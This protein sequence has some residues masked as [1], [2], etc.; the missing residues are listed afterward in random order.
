[1]SERK[2]GNGKVL[3]AAD[4]LFL[5]YFISPTTF[6]II[7]VLKVKGKVSCMPPTPCTEIQDAHISQLSVGKNK[8]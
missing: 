4:R 5:G 7:L 1:M 8:C 2:E 3:M 6:L